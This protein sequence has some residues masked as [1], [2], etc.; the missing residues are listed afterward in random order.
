MRLSIIIKDRKLI[1]C[2]QALAAISD[3]MLKNAHM[4]GELAT[5]YIRNAA[6]ILNYMSTLY[7]RT[8]VII[9][10]HHGSLTQDE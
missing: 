7:I 9:L 5:A 2:T 6:N 3:Q 1:K 4:K 8:P 10:H